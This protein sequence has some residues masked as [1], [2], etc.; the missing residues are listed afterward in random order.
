M[1]IKLYGY[2]RSS[3]TY[4]LR[5]VLN[6]KDIEY[7]YIPVHL[8]KNGGEQHQ[9]NY[10]SL[11][12][13]ELVPTLIDD[14]YDLVLNQSM[15]IIEYLDERYPAINRLLP[16]D[17]A[18]KV[19]VRALSQD[20]ACDVQPITNLRIVQYLKNELSLPDVEQQ[21]W[22]VHW[23]EKGLRSVEKRL[24]YTAG[25]YCFA[26]DITMADVCLIPQVYNALRYSID[27]NAFPLIKQ[28]YH[29][30]NKLSVFDAAKP[31]NQIDAE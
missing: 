20:I 14:D 15:A 30:C 3:A 7:E 21:R 1:S 16:V 18:D 5:I 28:I 22:L 8:V 19:R 9:Q 4:R 26:N 12:P 23:I 13:T 11:N 24:R 25:Q 10:Q 6:L 27:L 17:S 2:W 31:E 29:N